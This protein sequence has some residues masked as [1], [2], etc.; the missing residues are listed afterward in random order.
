MI[1]KNGCYRC[2]INSSLTYKVT[3]L[4]TKNEKWFSEMNRNTGLEINKLETFEIA[5]FKAYLGDHRIISHFP[6]A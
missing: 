2:K 6:I 4:E 1:K 5:Q 3:G